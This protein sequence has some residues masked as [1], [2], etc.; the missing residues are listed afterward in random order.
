MLRLMMSKIRAGV[1]IYLTVPAV[2]IIDRYADTERLKLLPVHPNQVMN[3]YLKWVCKLAGLLGAAD[4]VSYVTQCL[5]PS[6]FALPPGPSS[7]TRTDSSPLAL[8]I[9][10]F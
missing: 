9:N 10:N 7:K 8:K 5:P 1:S 3:K 2:A 6:P 4:L